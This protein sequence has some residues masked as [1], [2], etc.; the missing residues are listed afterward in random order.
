MEMY[1]GI[2][3][4]DY[5]GDIEFLENGHFYISDPNQGINGVKI[6]YSSF[7]E[8]DYLGKI[9]KQWITEYG[10]HHEL[11]PLSH[12]QT[13]PTLNYCNNPNNL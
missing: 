12:H 9:Y 5:A 7:I 4:G 2:L 10:V 11:V 1:F 8:I 6:N 3:N 13:I